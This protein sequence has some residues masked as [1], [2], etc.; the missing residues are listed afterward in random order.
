MVI[1]NVM[2][3][4]AEVVISF[5][6]GAGGFYLF[7]DR[8]GKEKKDLLE[9]ILSS[10]INFVLFIWLSKVILNFPSFIREPL[11]ILAY[12]GTA[13]TFYL[14]FIFSA[15][16]FLYQS[17]KKGVDQ[18]EF[19]KAFSLVFLITSIIYELIQFTRNDNENSFGYIL[20]LAAVLIIF[21]IFEQRMKTKFL[22]MVLIAL[23]SAGMLLLNTIYP[24]VTVFGYI[25]RPAF[26]ILFFAAGMLIVFFTI[27]KEDGHDRY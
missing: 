8:S 1:T 20:L 26:I 9:N 11:T 14:A 27:G 5:V 7:S 24:V 19:I 23:W 13:E 22:I 3:S 21:L 25:M 2:I 12:P 18:G 15:G 6:A 17:W 10:L 16:L 4:V